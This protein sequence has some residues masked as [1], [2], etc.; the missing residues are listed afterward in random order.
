MCYF[1][2]TSSIGLL[3]PTLPEAHSAACTI[4]FPLQLCC[5]QAIGIL[6]QH[7]ISCRTRSWLN[8][9]L[10]WCTW[11]CF[12]SL[13]CGKVL[14]F[15]FFR[16]RGSLCCPCCPRT[17]F[18]DQEFRA[19]SCFWLSCKSRLALNYQEVEADLLVLLFLL[20]MDNKCIPRL[21]QFYCQ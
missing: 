18:V 21:A 5:H 20:W 7:N 12:I 1:A 19:P 2:R 16:D 14:P 8:G 4:L 10:L 3:I 15:L 13:S 11:L 6:Q 17:F 9:I